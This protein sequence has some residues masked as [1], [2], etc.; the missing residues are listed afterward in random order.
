MNNPFVFFTNNIV[1]AKQNVT[2]QDKELDKA[3]ENLMN[4]LDSARKDLGDTILIKPTPVKL[5]GNAF[6]KAT[7]VFFAPDGKGGG[8]FRLAGEYYA[9]LAVESDGHTEFDVTKIL[10]NVS[11]VNA[12]TKAVHDAHVSEGASEERISDT[13]NE[14]IAF[15]TGKS[16][17]A[18]VQESNQNTENEKLKEK[19]YGLFEDYHPTE[20]DIK[21]KEL[22]EQLNQ[23]I[24]D[25]H[26][27]NINPIPLNDVN[28]ISLTREDNITEIEDLTSPN[29]DR[30]YSYYYVKGDDGMEYGLEEIALDAKMTEKLLTTVKASSPE[31]V[32]DFN[33]S[34]ITDVSLNEIKNIVSSTESKRINLSNGVDAQMKTEGN[35]GFE[36]NTIIYSNNTL[37]FLNSHTGK[38]ITK[39]SISHDALN[40]LLKATVLHNKEFKAAVE[41]KA[42]IL[43]KEVANDLK[44]RTVASTMRSFPEEAKQRIQDFAAIASPEAIKEVKETVANDSEVKS[45]PEKWFANAVEE[46]DAIV[47]NKE[48]DQRMNQGLRR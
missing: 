16:L 25:G 22:T 46:F 30:I 42:D 9:V 28:I 35:P 4:T 32:E 20:V 34:Y 13:R 29:E 5:A 43:G 37:H 2:E 11:S 1:M 33:Y 8:E 18:D 23:Y 27:V 39:E 17:I 36:I 10:D 41:L 24:P 15:A 19:F 40:N 26:I 45:K 48:I 38:E 6:A 14:I 44:E 3:K 7:G 21:M 12:L 47:G 31:A